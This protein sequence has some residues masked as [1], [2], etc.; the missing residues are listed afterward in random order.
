M[1]TAIIALA[2]A[3]ALSPSAAFAA[4]FVKGKVIEVD[5]A[6]RRVTLEHGDIPNLDMPGMTMT[7]RVAAAV[8]IE[9]FKP[10]AAVEFTADSVDDEI[11]VTEVR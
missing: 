6:A 4:D 9:N 1:R 8:D 10:G 3:S 5:G 2:A 11:A 7:F